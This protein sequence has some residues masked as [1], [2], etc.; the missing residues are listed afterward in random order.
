MYSYVSASQLLC[1]IPIHALQP[2][3]IGSLRIL[4]LGGQPGS[5]AA[6]QI[7]SYS[8][9]QV[10]EEHYCEEWYCFLDGNSNNNKNNNNLTL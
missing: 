9:P 1:M 7:D 6:H 5:R 8:G 3:G 10:H 2:Q 4:H